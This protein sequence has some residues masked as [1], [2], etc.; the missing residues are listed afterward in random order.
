MT[1]GF[2]PVPRTRML[3]IRPKIHPQT[4]VNTLGNKQ[5]SVLLVCRKAK[6]GFDTNGSGCSV[7]RIPI[8]RNTSSA[9]QSLSYF[10]AEISL[11]E[12]LIISSVGKTM[13]SLTL[14]SPI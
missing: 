8:P 13:L 7:L 12:S 9:E 4:A 1:L 14:P 10:V 6:A 2:N 11:T 3:T 5:P